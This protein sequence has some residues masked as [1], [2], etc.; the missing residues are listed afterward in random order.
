V[1]ICGL[2]HPLPIGA[3][4]VRV[5]GV[6]V[7]VARKSVSVHL[8]AGQEEVR[9]WAFLM[10]QGQEE[11]G[12]IAAEVQREGSALAVPG[13]TDLPVL[14][15]VASGRQCHVYGSGDWVIKVRRRG[16]L[17]GLLSGYLV[18]GAWRARVEQELG[19]LVLPF[20][21]LGP[22]TFLASEAGGA[23][24]GRKRQRVGEALALPRVGE[25]EFLDRVVSRGG[26]GEVAAAID[27]QLTLLEGLAERGFYMI[28]F[29]MANFV[30]WGGRLWVSDHGLIVPSEALRYPSPRVTANWFRK[31][32][33]ADYLR[34]LG[35]VLERCD[36]E[37]WAGDLAAVVAGF[38]GRIEAVAARAAGPGQRAGRCQVA[39]PPELEE[40]IRGV[41]PG[42]L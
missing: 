2:I 1:A 36:G 25:G 10:G 3:G 6:N 37:R 29:I 9:F 13:R 14:D 35:E 21:R 26:A 11:R 28:D 42:A 5:K 32:M 8:L 7:D 33:K 40:Q 16:S 31:K 24:S 27:A 12:R 20:R 30:W 19:G 18:R 23:R 38:E 39:F 17:L 15:Y 22:I 4:I 41:F 34:V